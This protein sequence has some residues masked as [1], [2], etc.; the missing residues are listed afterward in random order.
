MIAHDNGEVEYLSEG[1]YKAL[2]QAS[3]G[4]E[5]VEMKED[6]ALLC[7]HEASP[8]LVVTKVLT[9]QPQALEDQRCNIFQTRV[10]IN[11]KSI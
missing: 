1:E 3:V 6:E 9:T 7:V 8:S 5:D 11:G 10:G 2:V 4:I